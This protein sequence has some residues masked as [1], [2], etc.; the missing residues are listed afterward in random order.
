MAAVRCDEQRDDQLTESERHGAERSFSCRCRFACIDPDTKRRA[1]ADAP[2][3]IAERRI[4]IRREA[5]QASATLSITSDSSL[6]A[7]SRVSRTTVKGKKIVQSVPRCRW[8]CWNDR[9][10]PSPAAQSPYGR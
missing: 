10:S 7:F 9:A 8:R 4:Q 5:K 3:G 2:G 6:Q 1:T